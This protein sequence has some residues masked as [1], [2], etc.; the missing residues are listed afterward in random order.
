[1]GCHPKQCHYEE[2]NYKALRRVALL[3]R[4]LVQLGVH[5]DRVQIAWASAAQGIVFTE[6]VYEMTVTIGKLGP[7]EWRD[8]VTDKAPRTPDV[9]H[10]AENKEVIY[11]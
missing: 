2:G 4:T 5:P 10:E 7:L 1:M 11:G 6:T 9:A 3:R 8:N